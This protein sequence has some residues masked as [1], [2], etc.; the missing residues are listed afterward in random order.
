MIVH[1]KVRNLG[2]RLSHDNFV[3]VTECA[4]VYLLLVGNVSRVAR[5]VVLVEGGPIGQQSTAIGRRDRL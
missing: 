3:D 1:V 5:Q 2:G 4:P